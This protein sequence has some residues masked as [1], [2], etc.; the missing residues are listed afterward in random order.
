[1]HDDLL[2]HLGDWSF[3]G[4]DS[5]REFYNRLTCKNIILILGNHDHHIKK[6]RDG[7]RELFK[8]VDNADEDYK[9]DRYTLHLAHYPILSWKD[10]KR[11]NIHLHG[12]THF[13]GDDRFGAGRRMDIGIDGHPEFR[14]YDLLRE[15]IPMM[16]KRPIAYDLGNIDHHSDDIQN[17]H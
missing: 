10:I 9:I 7:I 6:N 8:K 14:P 2:I 12:H 5:I 13:M 16:L 15:V 4:F 1:M 17:R 11:G 3:S